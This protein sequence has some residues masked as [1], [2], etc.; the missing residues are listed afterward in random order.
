MLNFT[1]EIKLEVLNS[2]RNLPKLSEFVWGYVYV[3]GV[4]KNKNVYLNIKN[5]EIKIQITNYLKKLK[6][7]FDY[8]KQNKQNF[9]YFKQEEIN[10]NRQIKNPSDFFAGVFC[11][12]GN[13]QKLNSSSYHLSISSFEK[14]HLEFILKKLNEYDFGFK[15]I[16]HKNKF[17]IYISK[18]EKI[19]DFLKAIEA[20]NSYFVFEDN[21]INRDL[22]NNINR[23]N[24]IDM[25][26]LNKISAASE[27]YI[28]IIK[29]FFDLNLVKFFN[30]DQ[31]IFFKEKILRPYESLE[32]ISNLLKDKYKIEVKK[33]TLNNWLIKLKKVVENNS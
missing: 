26:N 3:A 19:S 15:L 11:A 16:K 10:L 32:N 24:N 9:I 29:K 23:I 30:N 28:P 20:V 13:T 22:T 31:I 4:F 27:K 5:R 17:L 1:K 2:Q 14:K 8:F 25:C 12:G 6:I 21:K 7:N 18:I 33:T